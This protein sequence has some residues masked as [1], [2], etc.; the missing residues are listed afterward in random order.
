MKSFTKSDKTES[1]KSLLL[2]DT[3]IDLTLTI[4]V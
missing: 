3:S 2:S 4:D 1:D